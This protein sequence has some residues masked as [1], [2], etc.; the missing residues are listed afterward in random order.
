MV[1][2]ISAPKRTGKEIKRKCS[3]NKK[4]QKKVKTNGS[5]TSASRRSR[6]TEDLR[7]ILNKITNDALSTAKTP[8]P[9]ARVPTFIAMVKTA[10]R[11][12]EKIHMT[13]REA[14]SKYIALRYRVKNDALLKFA[15]KWMTKMGVIQ[16]TNGLFYFTSKRAVT[17]SK[18]VGKVRKEK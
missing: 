5:K 7:K 13:S 9:S 4:N 10:I 3:K 2:R 1:K 15:L 17:K 16:K 11:D 8:M 14:L 18:Y 12:L 6:K